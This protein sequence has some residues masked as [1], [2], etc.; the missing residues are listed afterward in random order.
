MNNSDDKIIFV[1][2]GLNASLEF[3]KLR[4]CL[5]GDCDLKEN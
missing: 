1:Q 3:G 5:N 2:K 4:M